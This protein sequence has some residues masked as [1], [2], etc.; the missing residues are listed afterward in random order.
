MASNLVKCKSLWPTSINVNGKERQPGEEF[1]EEL[2]DEIKTLVFHKYISA[3]IPK[4]KGQA[5]L[6]DEPEAAP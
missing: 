5:K 3:D 1:E 2:T 6:S 4:K